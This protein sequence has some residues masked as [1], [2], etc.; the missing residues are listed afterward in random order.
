LVDFGLLVVLEDL[1]LLSPVLDFFELFF[2]L[3][4]DFVVLGLFVVLGD[5]VDDLGLFVVSRL[6]AV[7]MGLNS[8]ALTT[9][10]A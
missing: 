1:V 6:L 7:T 4:G 3:L 2:E 10:L 5:F 9:G 8:L